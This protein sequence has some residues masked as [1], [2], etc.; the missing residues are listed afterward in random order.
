MAQSYAVSAQ[1]IGLGFRE[2]GSTGPY[3]FYREVKTV[4]EVGES[5]DK[6]DVTSLDAEIKQYIKDIPDYSGDLE[7][8]MNAMPYGAPESN[9]EIVHGQ[10]RNATYDWVIM[11]PRLGTKVQMLGE[12]TWRMGAGA[13]SSAMELFVSVIPKSSPAWSKIQDGFTITYDANG[14]EGTTE[15]PS[16]YGVGEDVTLLDCG[17]TYEGRTFSHWSTSQ[18][19]AGVAYDPGE[20]MQIYQDTVLY[21]IWSE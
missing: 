11:Y 15:D 20:T 10:S 7:F 3:T 19:N 17:F 21:A 1:G 18:D 5:A 16:E 12:W 8:S 2:P 14:G 6:I 13:V 9:L 4:P